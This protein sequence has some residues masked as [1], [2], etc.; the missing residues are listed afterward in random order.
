MPYRDKRRAKLPTRAVYRTS[1]TSAKEVSRP[2][3][4]N[5]D[6]GKED[7]ADN[8]RHTSQNCHYARSEN[9]WQ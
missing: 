3:I 1:D 5:E 8:R 9:K 7:D 2:T 4:P 6:A